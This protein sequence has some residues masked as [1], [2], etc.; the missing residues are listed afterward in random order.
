MIL[1]SAIALE[2]AAEPMSLGLPSPRGGDC[3]G[4]GW[5]V[6]LQQ[7]SSVCSRRF[8]SMPGCKSN[9]GLTRYTDKGRCNES[10]SYYF[11]RMSAKT[12]WNSP[13]NFLDS[14]TVHGGLTRMPGVA[15]TF[16]EE[17]LSTYRGMPAMSGMKNIDM[18]G[19]FRPG[20]LSPN[21]AVSNP[22]SL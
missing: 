10:S 7:S 14:L 12:F 8:P 16:P 11:E 13:E 6:R 15:R 2:S 20:D 21:P 4:P 1:R 22:K 19:R 17:E 3:Y 5:L 18:S 9:G